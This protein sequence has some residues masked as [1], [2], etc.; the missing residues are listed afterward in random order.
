MR[1][2]KYF[3]SLSVFLWVNKKL[4]KV[5][6]PYPPLLISLSPILHEV[7]LLGYAHNLNKNG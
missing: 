7:E 4:L 5:T 3:D 6:N 2:N 1:Q